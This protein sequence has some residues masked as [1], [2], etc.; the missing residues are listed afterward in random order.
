[1]PSEFIP[2]LEG[3]GLIRRLDEYIFRYVCG[4]QKKSLDKKLRTLPIAVNMSRISLLEEGIVQRFKDIISEYGIPAEL[5]PIELTESS[6][7]GADMLKSKAEELRSAGFT[8]YLDDFGSGYSCLSNLGM[9]PFDAIK[10]GRELIGCIGDHIG[11]EVLRHTI[12]LS[13]FLRKEVIAEGVESNEQLVFLQKLGCDAAQGFFLSRPLG[14]DEY[15]QLMIKN[16]KAS[17]QAE[18]MEDVLADE[19]SLASLKITGDVKLQYLSALAGIYMSM[20]V[21]DLR[22][23]SVAEFSTTTNIKQHVTKASGADKQMEA[24]MRATVSPE[25]IDR[26]LQ[27]TDIN[28]LAERMRGKRTIQMDFVGNHFGWTRAQFV[29]VSSNEAEEPTVVIF[30]TQVVEADKRKDEQVEACITDELTGVYNQLAFESDLPGFADSLKRRKR[31]L[32]TALCANI[33]KL[34]E[35]KLHQGN[36]AKDELLWGLADCLSKTFGNYGNIYR[37]NNDNFVVLFAASVEEVRAMRSQLEELVENWIGNN[38]R[39]L[40]VSY[41]IASMSEFGDISAEELVNE[42]M[43]RS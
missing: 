19:A 23:N 17:S 20:H 35:I 39:S 38:V 43:K 29:V 12:E 6:A 5:V 9:V 25:Y 4:E 16:A 10:I 15:V 34:R 14:F 41:G 3:N 40:S 21:V 37:L 11:E 26:M 28:T 2:I 33:P 13:H 22:D 1:M 7:I 18:K 31:S 8:I 42:A 27:F 24:V 30:T 36:V 32:L